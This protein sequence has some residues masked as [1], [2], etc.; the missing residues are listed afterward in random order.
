MLYPAQGS[1][2]TSARDPSETRSDPLLLWND[3]SR[4]RADAVA[5]IEHG[6]RGA[7]A[8]ALARLV[9]DALTR[10]RVSGT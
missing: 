7:L 9:E 2:G 10:V 3:R 8:V 6:R 1:I 4:F 5:A